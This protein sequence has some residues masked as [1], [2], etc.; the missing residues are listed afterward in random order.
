MTEQRRH[1]KR[2]P[3]RVVARRTG[4][5]RDV[6]RAWEVRYG[7]VVP[8]RTPGGQRLYSDDDI[9]RLRL[10]QHAL[11]AGRRIG[12]VA[13]LPSEELA[14]LVA[15]DERA[16]RNTPGGRKREALSPLSAEGLLRECLDAVQAMDAPRLEST[17][18]LAAVT[19]QATELID[20]VVTPL[21]IQIGDL[22][23]ADHLTPAHERLAS[24][25]VRR[26]LDE[27]RVKLQS[28]DGPG[29]VVATPAGQ[30][31]E[32]G[33]MLA[34]ATAAAAGWR[35]IY[36][37]ADLPAASIA[38]AAELTRARAVALSLIYPAGDAELAEEIRTLRRLLPTD[39]DVIVGGQAAASYRAVLE[40]IGALW[41]SDTPALR[42]ALDLVRVARGN[43]RESRST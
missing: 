21:M 36:M 4:L 3:I 16:E 34:A 35:A 43:A 30:H 18:S 15:E 10:I 8:E 26:T 1:R 38:K 24:S 33:A 39:V 41:L 2:H 40:E 5:N 7:A 31:H 19:L 37:G 9:E 6:L 13:T 12:Q 32:I 42:S 25:V 28:G 11:G 23:W 20:H 14:R 27:I 17:L 29:L 22:W